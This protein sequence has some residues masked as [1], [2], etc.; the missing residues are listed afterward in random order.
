MNTPVTQSG[1]GL[2]TG[3][4]KPTQSYGV[5]F[6][7]VTSLFFM[8]GVSYGFLDVLNKHFQETL[9]ITRARSA[10]LQMS[11]FGAYFLLAMPAAAVIRRRGYK[12]AILCGLGLF[13]VGALMVIPSTLI[14]SFYVFLGAMFV[15]ASG[16]AF[17]ETAANPYVTLLGDPAHSARR[18]NLSQSFNGLGQFVA[19]RIAA[20]VLFGGGAN[21]VQH[22]PV[23]LIYVVI[24]VIVLLLAVWIW[25]TPMPSGRVA[26]VEEL[27]REVDGVGSLW[28]R[29]RFVGGVV[30]QFCYVAAQVGV[31]AFFINY[32]VEQSQNVTTAEAANMASY[33]ALCFLAGRFVGT[34]L[35]SKV[36]PALLLGI[37]GA[38]NV[39]LSVALASNWLPGSMWPLIALS[40]FMSIMFPTIFALAIKEL[41]P[42]TESA[43]SYLIMSIV[44][45]AI[46]PF[47]MGLV[48]DA[49]GI[50]AAFWIPAVC[51]AVVA[52]YG[53]S[54]GKLER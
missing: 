52:A 11:Y 16:L 36:R 35:M 15:I 29:K 4:L 20:V 1:V 51:F 22:A 10:W 53:V 25:R 24:A 41:G 32:A 34:A 26:A 46:V 48:A 2:T 44:G 37:Y 30:A 40:F 17:L 54:V 8:W 23:R 19:P 12:F 31:G 45:G 42:Q 47:C 13:A 27:K 18:L 28:A 43:A 50:A 5:A 49:S 9:N 21:A 14:P 39:L 38:I 33:A 3:N 7:L 6:A